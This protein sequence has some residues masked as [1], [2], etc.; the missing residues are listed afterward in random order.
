MLIVN[1]D[2][3][4]RL[5]AGE[6]PRIGDLVLYTAGSGS[7]AVIHIGMIMELRHGPDNK[8]RV[9]FVLS[10]WNDSSSE[11]VHHVDDVPWPPEFYETSFWTDRPVV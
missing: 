4:R 11:V 3:Y 6:T 2:G 7:K 5:A 10:K 9:P 8:L 1:E